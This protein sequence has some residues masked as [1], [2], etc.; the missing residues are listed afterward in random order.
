MMTNAKTQT[1]VLN[2]DVEILSVSK[3]LIEVRMFGENSHISKDYLNWALGEVI[4]WQQGRSNFTARLMGLIAKAD[5][6]N[7]RK[8]AKGFTTEVFAYFL[9]YHKKGLIECEKSSEYMQELR[10]WLEDSSL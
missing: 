9:W 5:S 2:S 1:E 10:K 3:N 7:K 8:I 6:S 4:G